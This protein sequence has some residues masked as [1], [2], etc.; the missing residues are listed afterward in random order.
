MLIAILKSN[1]FFSV[2]KIFNKKV[3]YRKIIKRETIIYL[4]NPVIT[5]YGLPSLDSH[6]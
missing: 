3:T 2:K 5:Y 6:R 1:G 4:S